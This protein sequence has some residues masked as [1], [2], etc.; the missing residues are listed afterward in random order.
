MGLKDQASAFSQERDPVFVFIYHLS[1]LT[2][3]EGKDILSLRST[4]IRRIKSTPGTHTHI[5]THCLV[6]SFYC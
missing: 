3:Q 2:F 1:I 6:F 5:Y 4:Q